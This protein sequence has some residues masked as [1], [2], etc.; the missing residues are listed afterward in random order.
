MPLGHTIGRNL[1]LQLR[2]S[3]VLAICFLLG[4]G[5]TIAEPAISALQAI[6][7]LATARIAH[8]AHAPACVTDART[9]VRVVCVCVLCRVVGGG[10][11]RGVSLRCAQ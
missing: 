11:A 2:A 5:V 4:V 1:P 8:T 7:T 3:L 6:G 9:H 10:G